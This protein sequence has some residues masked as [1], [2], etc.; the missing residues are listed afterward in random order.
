MHPIQSRTTRAQPVTG[1]KADI[2]VQPFGN[3][4][5]EKMDD[6][7]EKILQCVRRLAATAASAVT[8]ASAMGILAPGG[9]AQLGTRLDGIDS[10]MQP[11]RLTA[12]KQGAWV[13][14]LYRKLSF[15]F[16]VANGSM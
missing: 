9:D 10:G 5:A 12:N 7:S 1:D 2:S 4:E 16:L 14:F 6:V 13:G 11:L 3:S 8:G 15:V